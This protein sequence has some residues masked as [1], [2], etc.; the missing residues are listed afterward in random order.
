MVEK[1]PTSALAS[2]TSCSM[3]QYL[4]KLLT[5]SDRPNAGD[6]DDDNDRAPFF[7]HLVDEVQSAATWLM[8][9]IA[10]QYKPIS[11][12]QET[13]FR[14]MRDVTL[15]NGP[16]KWS[17]RLLG[18]VKDLIFDFRP[19][20]QPQSNSEARSMRSAVRDARAHV[21]DSMAGASKS[22]VPVDNILYWIYSWSLTSNSPIETEAW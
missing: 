14:S 16:I 1:K 15:I 11:C 20:A 4:P 7:D 8:Y 5:E 6:G 12:F 3:N 2:A 10:H 22:W 19:T 13:R 9:I 18:L 17:V 21:E